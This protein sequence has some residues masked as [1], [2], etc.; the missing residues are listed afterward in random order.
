MC[1]PDPRIFQLAAER[2][3]FPPNEIV[4][5]DDRPEFV[6]AARACGFHAVLF[7]STPEALAGIE[8]LLLRANAKRCEGWTPQGKP[9]GHDEGAA[10]AGA[11]PSPGGNA[12]QA[13]A[14]VMPAG[15]DARPG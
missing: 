10:P 8:A 15:P 5:L 1:K 3:G 14:P 12:D 11:A 9:A 2:I 6:E 7:T 4:F 13:E